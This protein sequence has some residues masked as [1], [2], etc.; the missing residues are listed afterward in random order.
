MHRYRRRY[1]LVEISGNEDKVQSIVQDSPVKVKFIKANSE[2]LILR[3]DAE[4]IDSLKKFVSDKGM[5]TLKVSGTID[6][7]SRHRRKD[8]K[9]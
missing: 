8:A 5:K 2:G 7:L 6:G 4:S 9:V 3:S 1:L